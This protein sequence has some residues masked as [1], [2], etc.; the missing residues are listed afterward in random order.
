MGEFVITA[1]LVILNQRSCVAWR[2]PAASSLPL[3]ASCSTRNNGYRLS[4]AVNYACCNPA[5]DYINGPR[6]NPPD[7]MVDTDTTVAFVCVYIP[8]R[9]IDLVG[10]LDDRL[11]GYGREDDLY[12]LKVR[13]AG[14]KIG[15]W[16]GCVVEH[17]SLPSSYRTRPDC[18]EL[19]GL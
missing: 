3:I 9:I 2:L 13:R 17:N 16:H 7:A 15:V 12:C 10:L 19:A 1:A 4:A 11:T 14:L 6:R 18:G 8:R 5:Q